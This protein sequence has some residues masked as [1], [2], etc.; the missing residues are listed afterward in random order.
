MKLV[1][2]LKEQKHNI[3][4]THLSNS[5]Y[6]L[7]FSSYI[8]SET[9]RLYPALAFLQRICME[10]YQVP[11]TDITLEKGTMVAIPVKA[12]HYDPE[13]Y[14]NPQQFQPERFA[15]EE[16]HKRHAQSFLGFGDG[17]RNCIGLRFGRMQAKVGLI[18]LLSKYRFSVSSKTPDEMEFSKYSLVMVPGNGV[19]LNAERV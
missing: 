8:F 5:F 18:A 7:I 1:H 4:I 9:L 14:E 2:N 19:W 11:D 10:D 16:I 6:F 13:I 17:P 12:I 15:S 3:F